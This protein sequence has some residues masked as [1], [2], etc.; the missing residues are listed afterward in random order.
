MG[1]QLAYR[2]TPGAE[3]VLGRSPE[4]EA[5][6]CE[7]AAHFALDRVKN[8]RWIDVQCTEVLR[9]A[10]ALGVPRL[11][12]SSHMCFRIRQDGY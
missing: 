10:E 1:W 7:R 3:D 12:P 6:R 11:L 8:R 4:A 9:R 2:G 5:R